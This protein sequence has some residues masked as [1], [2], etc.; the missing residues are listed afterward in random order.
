MKHL[1]GIDN[2]FLTMEKPD[3]PLH[4]ACLSIYD[5]STVPG[6][7]VRFKAILNHFASRM[8]H[9]KQ[10]RRKLVS[11]P[12]GI[13]RPYWID[14]PEIDLEYHVRHI[15]LPHPGD[16][17]QLMIQVAR[18][19][20]RP[21]DKTKPLWEAYVIEGLDNVPG[22]PRGGFALYVKIHHAAVDGEAGAQLVRALH[23][24]SPEPEEADVVAGPTLVAD[25]EPT[26]V[27]LY[28]RALGNRTHQVLDASKLLFSLG[29]RL[30]LTGK[31]ILVSGKALDT[32]K[33]L[34][35]KAID[36]ATTR[37]TRNGQ[38]G[39]GG[40]KPHT[41]F[42][43]PLTSHRVVDAVGLPL[44]GFAKIRER[45]DNVT[46]N[47]I[48]LATVG[49]AVRKYLEAK[50]ELPARS[51]VA[52][53][54][55]S[56]R[57]A[58]KDIDASNQISMTAVPIAS[59][60]A[61]PLD[62]LRAVRRGSGKSKAMSNA[63]GKDLPSRLLNILPATA[64]RL[65]LT[66][67]LMSLANIT[68]S[69][70]R[71]P[72]VPLYLAGA[73]LQSFLP[74]SAILSGL[75]LNVTGFS[76]NGTLWVC[77]VC[78]RKAMPDPAFFA[79]CLKESF[80]DLVAAAA[81]LAPAA[82]EASA[83]AIPGR[84]PTRTRAAAKEKAATPAT[85][86]TAAADAKPKRRRTVARPVAAPATPPAEPAAGTGP[87]AATRKPRKERSPATTRSNKAGAPKIGKDD[88]AA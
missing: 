64:T 38:G 4:V 47:D 43:D 55:M 62:R 36:A 17:R 48:F 29:S 69:N 11:L 80:N 81:D 67:G 31:D 75:G 60:V 74:V 39:I 56:T 14:E 20:S 26:A 46:I 78:C 77:A 28:A 41:R 37:G 58:V 25:R 53:V 52:M 1:S 50:G 8:H 61:A 7:K 73:R 87:G 84:R 66:K 59:D 88:A 49:G 54:P 35:A 68:V 34:I 42:D 86:E 57:S 79:E 22:V 82:G 71:G 30:A 72:D 24:L 10:F 18:I 83:A 33:E 45:V 9:W 85:P 3:Q 63:L 40:V 21:L 70:V 12:L 51:V 76:Y 65:L 19:H 5:P 6:G 2:L 13:D 27:E 16:W 23:S 32:G 44:D 15:A